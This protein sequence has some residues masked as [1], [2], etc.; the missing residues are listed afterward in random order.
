[1]MSG[2]V[3]EQ[4]FF[5]EINQKLQ[6][7]RADL[8]AAESWFYALKIFRLMN[9]TS[10]LISL[11][12]LFV[13]AFGFFVYGITMSPDLLF[14]AFLVTFAVYGLNRFTDRVEDTINR[15][16]ISPRVK[17]LQLVLSA[18]AMIAGLLIG[19]L[20]GFI[21]LA[22]L[23]SPVVIGIIYS[24]KISKAFHRLKE[25]T[26]VKSVAVGLSWAI[27][28]CLLPQSNSPV[29]VDLSVLVFV[30]IFVKVLVGTILCDVLDM[31]GDAVSGIETI[32]LRLGLRKTKRFLI[33]LNSLGLFFLFYFAGRG[34]F[35]HLMPTVVFGVLFGYFAIWWFL[36]DKCRR[37]TASLMLDLEWI[38]ILTIGYFFAM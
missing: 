37:V 33:I 7:I 2:K 26:G 24:V 27:T 10:L 15:P 5:T 34:V 19:V 36:R 23:I 13:A 3:K 38:P 1:M 18:G 11:N 14:A 25:I 21:V 30:F 32:P 6:K 29:G 12:G 35:L 8:I 17:S 31:R 20:E 28:G 4:H 9:S 22:I 16:E